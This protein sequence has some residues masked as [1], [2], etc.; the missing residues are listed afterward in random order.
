MSVGQGSMESMA[1]ESPVTGADPLDGFS[2]ATRAWFDGA[3]A[4]PT[5][6]QAGAW[7]AIGKGED[8]LVV[9]PTGS[10]KTLAAFLWAIDRLAAVAAARG[11]EAAHPGALRLPAQGAG[12][13]HRAEPARSA[14]RDHG[15]PR[16]GSAWTSRT[17]RWRCAPATPPPR[18]AGSW[19]Q[20][21][22]HPHHHPGVALPAAHLAGQGDPARGRD[23]HR[24]RGAR[25]RGQQARRPPG[26]VAG[27]PRRAARG[28]TLPPSGSGCPRRCGRSRRW[29]RSS[30]APG[31]VTVVQPPSP[32]RIELQVVVPVEDM[33]E[34][35][36]MPGR[37][38]GDDEDN[39]A[40]R[41]S[42]WPH[43]EERVLDLIE[44][45]KST[46]VFAN[47]RRLAER[48]CGRLNELAA[49]R[50]EAAGEAALQPAMGDRRPKPPAEIMAQAGASAGRAR[51]GRQGTPRL[52]VPAGAGRDRG[53]AQ[54]GPAA[55]RGGHVQPG[56]RHRH[57]RGGPGRAGRG[58]ALGGQRAA[59]GRPGRAQRRRRLPRH[60]LPQVPGRPGPV[61][62]GGRAHAGR[63]HRGTEDPAQPAGRAGPADRGDDGGRR[64][65][66]GRARADGPQGRAV[67]RAD[68]ADPRGGAGHAGRALPERGVRRAAAAHR[69]GPGG[70]HH[71]GPAWRAA[72]R[73]HQRRHH[74]RPR[75]VRRVPGVGYQPAAA[76]GRRTRRGDGVRVAG[77]RRVRARRQLVA[78]RGHHAGPGAGHARAGAAG[79]AAVLAR[80]HPGAARRARPGHRRGLP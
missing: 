3:F 16:T 28:R 25:R 71:P 32:K 26:A 54:G 63:R 35:D 65:A 72:A 62:G 7:R 53:G 47:S 11:P 66:G 46:I 5:Q 22:G 24:G 36:T 57:G 61:G 34:L 49:E 44:Q 13:G 78:D 50:A 9:A 64:L 60:H 15:T 18:S 29:P 40:P 70:G 74:P 80:R 45:H 20:A 75:A 42:I 56:T 31:T 12:G 38:A 52:G 48:L 39:P 23:G 4:E 51:G 21:A 6:A 67:R 68:Q 19:P 10:G 77:R 37:G 30:A 27:A 1:G 76:P 8:T 14:D 59:A 33:T 73:R 58:A 43:V 79:Q 69:L 55:R 41:R 2:P 17:S